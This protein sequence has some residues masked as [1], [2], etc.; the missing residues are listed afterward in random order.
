VPWVPPFAIAVVLPAVLAAVANFVLLVSGKTPVP[1][2]IVGSLLMGA[3]MMW[4]MNNRFKKRTGDA[5][6]IA[7][8]VEKFGAPPP[9]VGGW[10]N[11]NVQQRVARWVNRNRFSGRR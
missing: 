2:A 11:P 10:A 1:S 4:W 9:N 8:H 7:E 5:A 3:V 6:K